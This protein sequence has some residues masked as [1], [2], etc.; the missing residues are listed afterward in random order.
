MKM[1][2]GGIQRVICFATSAFDSTAGNKR[3]CDALEAA[4]RSAG[5]ET[6]FIMKLPL[7]FREKLFIESQADVLL[8]MLSWTELD[9]L[10]A[11]EKDNEKDRTKIIFTAHSIPLSDERLQIYCEQLLEAIDKIMDAI[12][13]DLSWE[14]A[15]QSASGRK[16]LWLGPDI[17]ERIRSLAEEGKYKNVVLSPLGFFCENTETQYDLDIE[18]RRVCAENKIKYFRA[19]A[20]GTSPKICRMIASTVASCVCRCL[21]SDA[22]T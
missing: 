3:Y 5:I 22:L 21:R 4:C 19:R 17:N 10:S 12:H 8:E 18:T 11:D 7:P 20:A 1:K 15:F 9:N 2:Q 13:S 14:L 16:E 6:T